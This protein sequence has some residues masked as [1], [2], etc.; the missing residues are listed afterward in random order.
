[1]FGFVIFLSFQL[2]EVFKL[3][4]IN[5]KCDIGDAMLLCAVETGKERRVKTIKAWGKIFKFHYLS[6]SGKLV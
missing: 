5:G 4:H 6:V 3:K 2:Y 1:L